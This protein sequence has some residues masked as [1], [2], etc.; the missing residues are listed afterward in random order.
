M[1]DGR[2]AET[3][4]APR[5]KPQAPR[6]TPADADRAGAPLVGGLPPSRMM[7]FQAVHCCELAWMT[8]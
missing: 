4:F 2:E 7:F 5:P 3:S 1:G 8:S 6:L